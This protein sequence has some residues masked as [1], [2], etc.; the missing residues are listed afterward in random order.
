MFRVIQNNANFKLK[1]RFT[2]DRIHKK[3]LISK[4]FRRIYQIKNVEIY[5][6]VL[7]NY[8]KMKD[9][10][11]KSKKKIDMIKDKWNKMINQWINEKI[12]DRIKNE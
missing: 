9:K 10:W 1:S 8:K 4:L 3:Y 12:N 7:E 6:H 2:F 11:I 5:V